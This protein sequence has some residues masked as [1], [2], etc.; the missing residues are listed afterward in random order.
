MIN[1]IMTDTRATMI[2][3]AIEL[4]GRR[5]LH[6]ASLGNVLEH[7]GTPRGS[8][9]HHFPGGKDELI[10]AALVAVGRV[11]DEW[12]D[13]YADGT[14]AEIT[15]GFLE[16]WRR[17]LVDSGL[18]AGCPVLAVTVSV[19]EGALLD[20]A[21]AVFRQGEEHLVAM[22][23]RAGVDA[24]EAVGFATFLFAAAE[25]A[26]VLARAQRSLDPFERVAERLLSTVPGTAPGDRPDGTEH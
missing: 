22:Y 19:P 11:H 16:F 23:V 12:L 14:P 8:I 10:D 6:G 4:L 24:S 25:G 1:V 2:R 13:R 5:G 20:R 18:E 3:G 26:V 7:T 21:G 9:Y 15:A 17:V